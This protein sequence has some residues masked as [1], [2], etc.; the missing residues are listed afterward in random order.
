RSQ[1]HRHR[2]RVDIRTR[3]SRPG[4]AD[5]ERVTS[6]RQAGANGETPRCEAPSLEVPSAPALPSLDRSILS[7]QCVSP[8]RTTCV[9]CLASPGA[10]VSAPVT[11]SNV[12]HPAPRA[13]TGSALLARLNGLVGLLV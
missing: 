5:Y 12:S 3:M 2:L 10:P 13:N 11:N 7:S 1:S 9:G 4:T 8:S 6:P